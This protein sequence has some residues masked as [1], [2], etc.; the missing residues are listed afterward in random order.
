MLFT[1]L[2]VQAKKS[3]LCAL[4]QRD[5]LCSKRDLY[6]FFGISRSTKAIFKIKN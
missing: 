5:N 6:R 4:N 2:H 3:S 1:A